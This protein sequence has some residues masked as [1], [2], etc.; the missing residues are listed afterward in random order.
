MVVFVDLV[1]I[2]SSI[3]KLPQQPVQIITL[4]PRILAIEQ[5][6]WGNKTLAIVAL[7]LLCR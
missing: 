7:D 1:S 6:E 3:L 4:K 5:L 2:S